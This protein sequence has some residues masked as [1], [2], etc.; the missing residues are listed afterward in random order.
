M[1]LLGLLSDWLEKII[2]A[3]GIFGL[4]A[5]FILVSLN[6]V[7]RYLFDSDLELVEELTVWIMMW[8]IYLVVGVGLKRGAHIA[9]DILPEKL[10][11]RARHAL[12]AVI[13]VVAL[14]F[15]VMFFIYTLD[16]VLMAKM[17][18]LR[19]VSS[20]TVPVWI[21]KLCMPIGLAT[22]VLFGIEQLLRNLVALRKG[23]QS[24]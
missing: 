18:R 5:L 12:N 21:T 16:A 3:L 15:G 20:I 23:G 4:S 10:H 2:N 14:V 13:M 9:V 19:T 7:T 17:L 8:C 11:G 24:C 6:I 1:R 22:F